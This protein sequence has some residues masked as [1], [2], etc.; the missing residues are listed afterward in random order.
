[1]PNDNRPELPLIDGEKS[2]LLTGERRWTEV[3]AVTDSE[4]TRIIPTGG[5]SKFTRICIENPL[6]NLD[7]EDET[8]NSVFIG[9][10]DVVN[11]AETLAQAFSQQLERGR[12]LAPGD[13]REEDTVL[14][15]YAMAGN[16]QGTVYVV[17]EFSS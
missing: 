17:V 16:G 15:P 4:R 7:P 13:H 1:M 5:K 11:D 10:K 14:A 9:G 2:H 6:E 3:F 12:Q 8:A